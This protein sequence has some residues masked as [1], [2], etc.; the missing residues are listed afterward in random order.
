MVS[1]NDSNKSD[2]SSCPK[3]EWTFNH[4]EIG[5]AVEFSIGGVD[6]SFVKLTG[7][8]RKIENNAAVFSNLNG[9]AS[10]KQKFHPNSNII[11][12]HGNRVYFSKIIELKAMM[13]SV[14][15][16]PYKV[17]TQKNNRTH[18]RYDCNI[19]ALTIQNS[20]VMCQYTF[21]L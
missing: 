14:T 5:G 21:N 1:D 4:I 13:L 2:D 8:L 20:P 10:V 9:V 16:P 11:I 7:S 18:K 3:S 6:D 17:A 19:N 12:F 15:S